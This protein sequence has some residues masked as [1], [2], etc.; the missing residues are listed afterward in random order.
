MEARLGGAIAGQEG[1]NP[2][3]LG[4][5]MFA[6]WSTHKHRGPPEDP[7]LL[8][9]SL[10]WHSSRKRNVLAS[11]LGFMVKVPQLPDRL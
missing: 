1:L 3:Q 11:G 6:G 5:G 7:S 9:F 4:E 8:Y 10:D 2:E